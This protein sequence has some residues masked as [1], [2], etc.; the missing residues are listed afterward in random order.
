MK[1]LQVFFN[2]INVLFFSLQPKFDNWLSYNLHGLYL[3]L[4]QKQF[5]IKNFFKSKRQDLICMKK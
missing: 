5:Y 2:E 3:K 4:L 1:T